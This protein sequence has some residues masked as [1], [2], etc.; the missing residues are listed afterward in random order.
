MNRT[1]IPKK[2]IAEGTRH[3]YEHRDTIEKIRTKKLNLRESARMI[4]MDHLKED[5]L[6]YRKLQGIEKGRKMQDGGIIEGKLHSE[7]DDRSGCGEKF[8][9]ADSSKLIEAERG[10]A[11]I[12][13]KAVKRFP[14]QVWEIE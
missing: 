11:T 4:A 1:K 13:G 7:C 2:Q 12:T 5:P 3:E 6:Y 8:S 10:E 9:T 14:T